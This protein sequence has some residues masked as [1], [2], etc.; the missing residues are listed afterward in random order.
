MQ[1]F[2][3]AVVI[4]VLST[5]AITLKAEA[6]SLWTDQP[7]I[8]STVTAQ[9][10]DSTKKDDA[11]MYLKR[12]FDRLK[13][14]KYQEAIADFN[15]VIKLE[16]DNIYAYLGKGL[17]NFSLE[18]YQA[19]KENFDQALEISPN[20][21]HGYYFR[22][23]TRLMLSDNRGAIADLQK[24]STLFTQAGELELAQKADSAIEKIQ[25]S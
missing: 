7:R 23:F 6:R 22:G 17:G 18:N 15:Q 3:L 2:N 19:A 16:P 13:E 10:P 8:L 11:V 21:A 5:I 24:A 14:K 4:M 25:K 9:V 12:G 20:F 1:K